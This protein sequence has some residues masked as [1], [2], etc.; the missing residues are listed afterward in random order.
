MAP[1]PLLLLRV[2]GLGALAQSTAAAGGAPPVA[3]PRAA[4]FAI[5]GADFHPSRSPFN[6]DFFGTTPDPDTAGLSCG[7]DAWVGDDCFFN[8]TD[9]WLAETLPVWKPAAGAITTR[10]WTNGFSTPRLLGG[11]ADHNATTNT[12]TPNLDFEIVRRGSDGKLVYDF[13]R[14]DATLDGWLHA[15]KT[16][17]FLIVLDNIPYAFVKPENRYYLGFGP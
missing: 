12:Y 14:V 9:R 11:I 16:E 10:P 15:A 1:A 5:S 3:V 8:V 2:A 7:K 6:A 13:G 4:P 17:R